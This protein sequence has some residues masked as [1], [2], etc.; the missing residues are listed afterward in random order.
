M[1]KQKNMSERYYEK[2]E[3]LAKYYANKIWNEDNLG[4]EKEDIA[5]ELR[6]RL[7]ISIKTY[8]QRWAEYVETGK[9]KPV[10]IEFYLKSV[11][12][13]KSKDFIKE[14]N[15]T[16]FVKTSDVDF[17]F[18]ND[19]CSYI[20]ESNFILDGFNV[21][22][23]LKCER[24]KKIVKFHLAGFEMKKIKNIFRELY[25]PEQIDKILNNS[26]DI[27]RTALKSQIT[28]TRDYIYQNF[29]E[30]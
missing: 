30:D 11:M 20:D 27:I 12:I 25:D 6:L 7:F 23:F 24:H 9:G 19:D 14:I 17:D 28:S 1:E 15:K 3:H 10:P 18:G 21:L 26:L 13:N 4:L 2:Y 5:Q 22:N 29:S 16:R 8:G